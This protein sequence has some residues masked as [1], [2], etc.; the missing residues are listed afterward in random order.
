[1]KF[2]IL[3]KKGE[4][5][6]ALG[7]RIFIK[8]RMND[9]T[10][11]EHR[12]AGY[13]LENSDGVVRMNTREFAEAVGSSPAAVV[14]FSQKLGFRGFTELKLD[15]ARE[16]ALEQREDFETVIRD[17]DDME[18]I[19]RKAE[20]IHLRN[21]TLTYQMVNVEV[22]SQ[23]V[24]AL[25]SGRHIHL[26]GVGA[27]GLLAMDFLHKASRIGMPA[28]YY[29]DHHTSLA[30]ASLLGPGDIALAISYSGETRETVLAAK[31]ARERGAK[32]ITITK[33]GSN[34]LAKLSDYPLYVLGEEGEIRL[35]AMTS[36]ISGLLILDLLYLG[37]AKHEPQHT[38]K[39]LRKT[40]AI[41]RELQDR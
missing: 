36:R 21:T 35:G 39:S 28:F 3:S 11:T 10:E 23:A 27:S 18:T 20:R 1:M 37:M 31:A 13:L 7:C 24:K 34:S 6:A 16:T 9:L 26:F 15:L 4:E 2:A 40:R 25:C 22:L 17:Q 12:L 33:A 32:V 19:L 8:E 30:T 41:I 5:G 14:R 29:S 38:Q